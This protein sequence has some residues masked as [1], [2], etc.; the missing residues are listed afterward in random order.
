MAKVVIERDCVAIRVGFLERLMLAEKPRKLPFSSIRG[1]DAHPRLVEMMVHWADQSGVWLGGVSA[2]DGHLI[3]ATKNPNHTLAI[4][5]GE[6]N[7]RIFVEVEDEE[8]VKVAARIK[9]A[10]RAHHGEPEAPDPEDDEIPQRPSAAQIQLAE[11]VKEV[12][13]KELADEGDDEAEELVLQQG[14]HV[15]PRSSEPAHPIRLDSDHDLARL[16]GWLV[17]LGSLGV[18][19]GATIV[20]A[21]LVPGLLAVGAGLACGLLGGVALAVVAQHSE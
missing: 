11:M 15:P 18:L 6:D 19:T 2:Y 16:G 4:D 1:V 13:S 9:S 3:P 8:P 14:E 7:E 12:Q 10:L 20:A 5:M 17:G 21:G